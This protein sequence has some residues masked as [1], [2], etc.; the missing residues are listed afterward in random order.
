MFVS[1]EDKMIVGPR[2]W[3]QKQDTR[4]RVPEIRSK[5]GGRRRDRRGRKHQSVDQA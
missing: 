2:G 5:S 4:T 3:I 1:R